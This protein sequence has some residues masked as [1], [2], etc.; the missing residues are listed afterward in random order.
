MRVGSPEPG[1]GRVR[2]PGGRGLLVAV[3]ALAAA[4]VLPTPA[5]AQATDARLRQQRQQ[6]ERLRNERDRLEE[7]MQE[8]QGTMHDLS[9]EVRN[10]DQQAEATSELV[11]SL[12]QQLSAI[13]DEVGEATA[14]LVHAEDELVVKRAI[15]QQRL[16][17]IYKRG[18]LYTAEVLLSAESFADLVARY[19][20]L[21]LVAS[22]DRAL[23]HRVQELR[24]QIDRQRGLLVKLQQDI[25]R[26]R[27]EKADEEKRLRDLEQ[28][29]ATSL[30]QTKR[31]ARQTQA[32]LTQIARDEDRLTDFIA[33]LEAARL[34]A[35]AARRAAAERAAVAARAPRP[36]PEAPRT[37]TASRSLDWPVTGPLLY[38]F[39][40]VVNPNN[41]TTRWNGI[42]IQA[43]AGTP[44]RAVAAGT[45][46]RAEA[47][48]TYGLTVI[49]QHPGGDYS[50]YGSLGELQVRQGQIV[51]RGQVIGTVG[52]ADPD[53]PA[54]VHFEFR[55]EGRAVDPLEW[56]K[57]R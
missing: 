8:L 35:E 14:N 49:I 9:E 32:R 4:S 51:N 12:D 41:T 5:R 45:V 34:R 10:L 47:M 20:Y 18:P 23:V 13:N 3:L 17:D 7:R 37:V 26:N 15:L 44:V 1:V 11:R 39:G 33:S 43:A 46:V 27:T 6:L 31:S 55:P 52:S 24:D 19:K 28:Q 30:A 29:R 56:L 42:G 16:V 53:L 36:A 38:D 2:I 54:H 22:R 40:R 57:A 50:V 48:G 25:E 21:Y